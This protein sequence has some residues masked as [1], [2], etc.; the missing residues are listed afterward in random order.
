MT[1]I[2]ALGDSH[3]QRLGARAGMLA[4]AEHTGDV[5][6]L[7]VAVGGSTTADLAGQMDRSR[8]GRGD[9]VLISVGTNDAASWYP[10]EQPLAES[11][12]AAA[13]ESLA[14]GGVERAVLLTSPGVDRARLPQS[15][16]RTESDL[17]AFA[18]AFTR[19]AAKTSTLDVR[20]VDGQAVLGSLGV[21]AFCEDGMHLSAE[22]YDQL[23]PVLAAALCDAG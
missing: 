4:C 13:L 14:A 9:R 20:V 16:T 22:G 5:E 1:R 8:P 23:I 18:D 17:R 6:V 15:N 7:N 11:L 3:L 19:V 12:L 10:V 2:I 21:A